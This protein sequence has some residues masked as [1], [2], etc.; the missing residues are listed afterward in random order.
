MFAGVTV[1]DWLS[2]WRQNGSDFSY[3]TRAA[4]V[5]EYSLMNSLFRWYEN[6][7]FLTKIMGVQVKPPIFVLVYC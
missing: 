2:I 5:T 6:K 1:S 7:N 4:A 3:W